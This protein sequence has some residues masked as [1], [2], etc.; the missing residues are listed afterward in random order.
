MGIRL[1]ISPEGESETKRW[2][3]N[4]MFD[5]TQDECTE[6]VSMIFDESLGRFERKEFFVNPFKI[7]LKI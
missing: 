5:A 1:K 7:R 6:Y 4:F 3:A 2:I